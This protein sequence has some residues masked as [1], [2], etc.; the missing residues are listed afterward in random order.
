MAPL[1]QF[2]LGTLGGAPAETLAGA[3]MQLSAQMPTN[4]S[5]TAFL[6]HSMTPEAGSRAVDYVTT[7]AFVDAAGYQKAQRL[8]ANP[9]P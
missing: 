2:Y 4:Y 9:V 5:P 6:V 1:E 8:S 7:L 3:A